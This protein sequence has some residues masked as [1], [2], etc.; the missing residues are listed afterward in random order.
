[1]T[2]G[3]SDQSVSPA[4]TII[5]RHGKLAALQAQT[6]G[7]L[8]LGCGPARRHPEATTIDAL[9]FDGVDV[10]GDIFD[11]LAALPD[12][13]IDAIHSYHFV[14]HISPL[15]RL[16]GECA[17]VLRRGGLMHTV[18]PHFS[19]PYFYS[20]YTHK[21]T[22]GLYSFSY[23][24]EDPLFRRRV[25]RYSVEPEFVLDDVSLGFKAPPPF[26]VRYALRR[27]FGM[28]VNAS[29]LTQEWYEAGWT[30]WFPCYEIDVRLKRL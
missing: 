15:P 28:V 16:L 2:T 12:G 13:S 17:R 14:E 22:F 20:D 3:V 6:G 4:G 1:M 5:D 30:G 29:R 27:V 10:V 8:E 24:A 11:V 26:Y 7:T 18:V 9:P 25:P 23:L 21:Q 19:N